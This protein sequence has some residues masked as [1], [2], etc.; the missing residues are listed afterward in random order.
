MLI[1]FSLNKIYYI[2]YIYV[3]IN[4]YIYIYIYIYVCVTTKAKSLGDHKLTRTGSCLQN[5]FYIFKLL[6]M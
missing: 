1:V 5:N 2:L 4:M 6:M 3:Y